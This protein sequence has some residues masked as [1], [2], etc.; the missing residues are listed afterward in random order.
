MDIQK[1]EINLEDFKSRIPGL[2]PYLE[3]N[4]DGTVETHVATDSENGCYGKVVDNMKIPKNVRLTNYLQIQ[5]NEIPEHYTWDDSN[6][7]GLSYD[8]NQYFAISESDYLRKVLLYKYVKTEEEQGAIFVDE[9]PVVV[10]DES[11]QKVMTLKKGL[12]GTIIGCEDVVLY[13]FYIKKAFYYYYHR[14]D[15]IKPCE[16]YSYRTLIDEYYKYK[17]IVGQSNSFIKFIENGIG[18]ISVDRSLLN[19]EDYETYHDVPD[20][21]YLSQVKKLKAVY[22]N[23]RKAYDFYNT[24][25]IKNNKTYASLKEKSEKYVSMG[26]DNF[27][28]WL[29]QMLEKAYSISKYY[30]CLSDNKDF[31]AR[32]VSDIMLIKKNNVLGIEDVCENMFVP[33]KRY[34]DGDLLSYEGKTYVCQIDRLAQGGNNYHYIRKSVIT[35]GVY[36]KALLELNGDQ[37]AYVVISPSNITYFTSDTWDNEIFSTEFT[38]VENQFY[39]WDDNESVYVAIEVVEFSTGVFNEENGEYTFDWQHFIPLSEIDGYDKWYDSA[40]TNGDYLKFFVDLDYIPSHKIYEYIRFND[41]IFE[42]DDNANE[43]IPSETETNN[44][45]MTTN[46]KLRSLRTNRNYV[47]SFGKPEEPGLEEDWLF[48]YKVGT[49]NGKVIETDEVGNIVSDSSDFTINQVCYDLHAYGNIITSIE[50]NVDEN[51]LTFTYIIG[52]HLLA[53]A[54]YSYQDSDGNTIKCYRDFSYDE[55]SLDG[56]KYVEKYNCIGDSVASLGGD[57]GNYVN[58]DFD[59]MLQH[60]NEKYPFHTIPI[61]TFNDDVF[62]EGKGVATFDQFANIQHFNT[63]KSDWEVGLYY[64][65]KVVSRLSIDRGNGASFDRHVRLGE[66][67]NMADLERYQNGTFFKISET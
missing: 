62:I 13:D 37:D 49:I 51:T 43:Y 39:R 17:N 2:F 56:V 52:A 6:T 66:I 63:V 50:Y 5:E 48:Y 12:D 67:H 40:N 29:S 26:G 59:V 11:P 61:K 3:W 46:S 32:F 42:W 64:R 36:V 25:D 14:T 54:D 8:I 18:Y 44:V 16:T 65:P 45:T 21:I 55:N 34:Y 38:N 20:F 30:K 53:V 33:G 9:L 60:S 15:I 22:D 31:P 24:G 19:L 41:S 28:N 57:F 7:I 1:L 35:N 27:N 58:G 47:N 4:S 10:L 23:F